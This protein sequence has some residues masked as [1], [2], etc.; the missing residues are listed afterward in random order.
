MVSRRKSGSSKILNGTAKRQNRRDNIHREFFGRWFEKKR[1]LKASNT[2]TGFKKKHST[3]Q[4]YKRLQV[5]V[6]KSP[7]SPLLEQLVQA[8]FAVSVSR[9]TN[10]L[11]LSYPTSYLLTVCSKSKKV[12]GKMQV[13]EDNSNNCVKTRLYLLRNT[14]NLML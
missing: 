6:I 7:A 5:T 9:M 1:K 10:T 14:H 2:K 12:I 11:L 8:R 4:S 13:V 3:L